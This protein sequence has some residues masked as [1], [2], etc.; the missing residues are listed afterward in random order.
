MGFGV[1]V[2]GQGFSVCC[3]GVKVRV[4]ATLGLG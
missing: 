3:L 1:G 4:I 2:R